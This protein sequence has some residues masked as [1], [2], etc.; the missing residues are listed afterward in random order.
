[1]KMSR[2]L[3]L[4]TALLLA[5]AVLVS[6]C[7]NQRKAKANQPAQGADG[8]PVTLRDAQKAFVTVPK[9]PRRIVSV[10]PTVT[11]ILFAIGAGD[12]VVAV[13]DQCNYPPQVKKL[14]RVGGFFTPSAEKALAAQ[15]DLVIGQ[16]GNP[17]EFIATLRKAGVPVFTIAPETLRDIVGNVSAI[18]QVTGARAGASKVVTDMLIRLSSISE[19]LAD[20]PESKRPS[21]FIFSQIGPVW[22]AG[23]GTFQDDAIRAAGAHN[24]GARVKGFKEFSTEA[25]LAADPDYLIVSTMTG[26]PDLMKQQLL[27]NAALKRLTAVKAGRVIVLDGDEV[28][29]PGPRVVDAIE[30]MARAFYPDRFGRSSSSATSSR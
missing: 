28:M 7:G 16:R 12:R 10:T 26:T 14:P 11:E 17:P 1:M 22:T 6:G 18:G 9:R 8:F 5:G 30:A 24:A 15:P 3:A 25:L 2:R 13:S 4:L 29:R 27:S 21:A 23:S 19:K 20:V